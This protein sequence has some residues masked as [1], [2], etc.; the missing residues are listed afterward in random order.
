[1]P[2]AVAGAVPITSTGSALF[3]SAC[4]RQVEI[5]DQLVVTLNQDLDGLAL[6]DGHL[7][8]DFAAGHCRA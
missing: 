1:M 7:D 8:A 6:G 5:A 3:T 2:L 4:S